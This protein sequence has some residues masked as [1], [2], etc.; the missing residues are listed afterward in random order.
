MGRLYIPLLMVKWYVGTSGWSYSWNKGNSLEWF[1]HKTGANAIELNMSFYRFQFPNMVKSWVKKGESLTWV[2]K[3]HR[4]ITHHRRLQLD[5]IE[6]FRRFRKLFAP[7]ESKIAYFLFQFPPNFTEIDAVERFIEVI[8]S[9]K[10]AVEF[11]HNSLFVEEIKNWGK[12]NDL[13]LVSVDAPKLS[14]MIMSDEIL[15]LRLHGRDT[16]YDYNYKNEELNEILLHIR[17]AKPKTVFLFF[18]NYQMLPNLQFFQTLIGKPK[19]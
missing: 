19:V 11:R 9:E 15:Y 13:L 18:N 4:S 7:L 10:I 6:R 2:I 1:L 17:N 5:S 8:G 3:V 12:D 14:R 16:W